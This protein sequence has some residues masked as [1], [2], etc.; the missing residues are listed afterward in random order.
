VTAPHTK[1]SRDE[2]L[3]AAIAALAEQPIDR[4]KVLVLAERLGVARSSFY[5]YFQDRQE[6]D[7]ALVARWQVNTTS[8]VDRANRPSRTVTAACLGVF[9]CWADQ[10]LFNVPLDQAVREWA[11]RDAAMAEK[12]RIEDDERLAALTAM[13]A[14][15]GFSGDRATVRARLLYH[16]QI[17]YHLLARDE[18]VSRRVE[19]LPE[20]LMAL[21]G[22][23]APPAELR[24]FEQF[25]RSLHEVQRVGRSAG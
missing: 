8:I 20:Y 10:R 12:V 24:A 17:G 15:H 18:P 16:G 6:F 25:L 19:L 21:T 14:R 9:E 5:W 4:L 23:V 1:T 13:F 2:W 7:D 11:S 22:Q 3:D